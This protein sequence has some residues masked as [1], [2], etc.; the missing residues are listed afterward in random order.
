MITD[1]FLEEY[2]I[3]IA[4]RETQIK[5]HRKKRI[6]KKYRKRY[7]T[8]ELNLMPHNQVL[9]MDNK[10]LWMTKQTFKELKKGLGEKAK[11]GGK[12]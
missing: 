11:V 4:T 2:K 12:E 1:N 10:E 6:N 5:T 3:H 7:G 9:M 8:Q